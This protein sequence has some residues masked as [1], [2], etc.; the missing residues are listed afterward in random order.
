[1]TGITSGDAILGVCSASYTTTYAGTPTPVVITSGE[2]YDAVAYALIVPDVTTSSYTLT[3]NYG[4]YTQPHTCS[5]YEVS[6]VATSSPVDVYSAVTRSG[7]GTGSATNIT[8]SVTTTNANDEI[9]GVS[10]DAPLPLTP[11]TGYYS[12]GSQTN[13]PYLECG[14][15]VLSS[16]QTVN[17]GLTWAVATYTQVATFALKL[18]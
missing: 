8:G 7:Y 13:T 14:T 1:M 5:I 15:A 2:P 17:P 3:M 6:G 12:A 18:Q 16:T 10:T 9:C 11:G 4:A